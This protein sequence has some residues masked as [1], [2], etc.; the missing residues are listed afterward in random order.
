MSFRGTNLAILSFIR[1]FEMG[2]CGDLEKENFVARDKTERGGSSGNLLLI[3]Y[4]I[5]VPFQFYT[6]CVYNI[7]K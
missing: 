2:Y 6:L 7:F 1:V 4:H 5:F 3:L